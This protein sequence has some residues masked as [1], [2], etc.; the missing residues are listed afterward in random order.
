MATFLK[1]VNCIHPL[2]ADAGNGKAKPRKSAHLLP[3]LTSHLH[4]KSLL[5]PVRVSS[6]RL[7]PTWRLCFPACLSLDLCTV[8]S[9]SFSL[10]SF[11]IVHHQLTKLCSEHPFEFVN[12][13]CIGS[14]LILPSDSVPHQNASLGAWN[15]YCGST[16]PFFPLPFTHNTSVSRDVARIAEQNTAWLRH[17]SLDR[18]QNDA[19]VCNLCVLW[20]TS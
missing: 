15:L 19:H 3:R 6:Q 12:T 16:I 17:S 11:A 1:T 13:S 5:P 2:G 10:P 8:N 4:T 20:R 14:V 18:N 9:S 7:A